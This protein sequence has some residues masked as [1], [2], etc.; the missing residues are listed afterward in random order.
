VKVLLDEM[1]PIGVRELLPGHDVSTAAY[2][3]LAGIS[4]GEMIKRA[5]AAG[6]DVIVTLD[7]GIPHQQN[8]SEQPIGFVLL[9]DNDVDLIGTYGD[10]VRAAVSACTPGTVLRVDSRIR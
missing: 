9:A 3:G 8:L 4:N 10:D 6:F 1:L 5:I 2:V 7:R